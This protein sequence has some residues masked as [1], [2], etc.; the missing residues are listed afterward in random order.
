[1]SRRL[2]SSVPS[3]RKIASQKPALHNLAYLVGYFEASRRCSGG[4]LAAHARAAGC[5]TVMPRSKFTQNLATILAEAKSEF[6]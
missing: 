2:F 4:E 6:S 3:Q 5:G 1:V